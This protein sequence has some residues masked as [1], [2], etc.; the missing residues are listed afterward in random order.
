[1]SDPP[2]LCN[3]TL[4]GCGEDKA[5][6]PELIV[7]DPD[8]NDEY[9]AGYASVV[10]YVMSVPHQL[11]EMYSTKDGKT[12]YGIIPDAIGIKLF[13]PKS[14]VEPHR[15]PP[16][17]T[18]D[19]DEPYAYLLHRPETGERS[20]TKDELRAFTVSGGVGANFLRV[21]QTWDVIGN[22]QLRE[23]RN[24]L[25]RSQTKPEVKGWAGTA[26]PGSGISNTIPAYEEMDRTRDARALLMD[27]RRSVSWF[28]IYHPEA[29]KQRDIDPAKELVFRVPM[30]WF[31]QAG[32]AARAHTYGE[33][34]FVTRDVV[35]LAYRFDEL[36]NDERPDRFIV[37]R[38]GVL[39]ALGKYPDTY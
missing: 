34:V 20:P 1:M 11:E 6:P 25:M 29:L 39:T 21:D 18:R 36:W 8:G 12:W 3:L 7:Y 9:R 38:R 23:L 35:P 31:R 27:L 14:I 26:I 30:A 37:G 17:A 10:R 2:P 4:N 22:L 24:Q 16:P 13:A 5:T 15:P 32:R 28:Y 19:G 33:A